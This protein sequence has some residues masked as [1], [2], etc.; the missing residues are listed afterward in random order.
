MSILTFALAP[1]LV[2]VEQTKDLQNSPTTDD[3]FNPVNWETEPLN[4]DGLT[5]AQY[6]KQTGKDFGFWPDA[7]K[8]D[9][10]K[11]IDSFSLVGDQGVYLIPNKKYKGTPSES[12]HVVYANRCNPDV[13]EDFY[14]NK[15]AMFGCDD[16]AVRIPTQWILIAK[17]NNN[18]TLKVNLTANS[19]KLV[20]EKLGNKP[21]ILKAEMKFNLYDKNYTLMRKAKT[22]GSWTAHCDEDNKFYNIK[23]KQ[24]R[25]ANFLNL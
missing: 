14:E 1:L 18:S 16:G 2:I 6:T 3:L 17:E 12:G 11:L 19:V 25:E 9:T 15:R 8:I 7:S 22:R 23:A 24:L 10:S 4:A 13:D 5:E 21:K 20:S